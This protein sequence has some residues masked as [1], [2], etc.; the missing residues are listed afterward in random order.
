VFRRK[1]KPGVRTW[2]A[3][4]RLPLSPRG[5]DRNQNSD[6]REKE[7]KIAAL[8]AR[9][10][11]GRKENEQRRKRGGPTL[12]RTNRIRQAKRMSS[13]TK[14]HP[15]GGQP[16]RI[17]RREKKKKNINPDSQ[18]PP[19][20]KKNPLAPQR[21]FV[22]NKARAGG[23]DLIDSPRKLQEKEHRK[24]QSFKKKKNQLGPSV[25]GGRQISRPGKQNSGV[26]LA[27]PGMQRE[28]G[29]KK[30]A[31]GGFWV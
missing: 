20:S 30:N 25:A 12:S 19:Q 28:R 27:W 7:K 11:R 6:M 26:S 21:G 1:K 24:G 18:V 9:A 4:H 31:R 2:L 3:R 22:A 8:W 14:N 16:L 23:K 17:H 10:H 29:D 13:K 5:V 15:T